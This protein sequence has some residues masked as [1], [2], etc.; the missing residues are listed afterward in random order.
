MNDEVV[1]IAMKG[2]TSYTNPLLRGNFRAT[3]AR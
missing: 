3:F 1:K 2:E